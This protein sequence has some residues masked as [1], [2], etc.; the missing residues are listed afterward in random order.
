MNFTGCFET[1]SFSFADNLSSLTLV[2]IRLSF[3]LIKEGKQTKCM[4][5]LYYYYYYWPTKELINPCFVNDLTVWDFLTDY[6]NVVPNTVNQRIFI[7]SFR[8]CKKSALPELGSMF[9]LMVRSCP[10]SRVPGFWS[11]WLKQTDSLQAVR[12]WCISLL[13]GQSKWSKTQNY[14]QEQLKATNG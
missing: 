1:L 4:D 10:L 11:Y 5:N 14:F 6:K 8:P 3:S 12:C 2:S 13:F 7:K 9:Q